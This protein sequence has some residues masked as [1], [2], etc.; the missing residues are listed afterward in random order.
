MLIFSEKLKE[1]RLEKRLTQLQL[2]ER[3]HISKAMISSYET[4]VRL[5]SYDVLVKIASL[6]G[7]TTDFLLGLNHKRYMDVT[8]VSDKQLIILTNLVDEFKTK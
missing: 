6:F 8:G 1:L 3:L 7:V 5:P 4:G 2:A